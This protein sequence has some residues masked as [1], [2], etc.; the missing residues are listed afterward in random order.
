MKRTILA[1]RRLALALAGCAWAGIVHAGPALPT[2][3]QVQQ[4]Q[5]SAVVNGNKLTVTNSNGAILN[6]SSFSIGAANAV[7]FEQPGSTSKVLNRVTG[8]DPSQILGSLSSNGQVWLLNP[9]GVLFG[10]GARVDVAGLVTSTLNLND[11]DWTAG[12]YA[13]TGGEAATGQVLNQ[14]EIRSAAGGQ[15]LLLAGAGG[16]RNEGLIDTAGGQIVL[17]AGASIE[18]L[19]T[20]APRL[21]VHVTAPAGEAL[22][23]GSIA[24]GRIDVQAASVNQLGVVR[25]DALGVGPGGEIVLQAAPGQLTLGADSRTTADAAAGAGGRIELLG[26]RVALL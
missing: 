20:A 12:R 16:V 24:G 14:G 23:L 6:W 3:L 17:A 25:A 11:L 13:F 19:D 26:R 1:P 8:N 5:A 10:S 15:V 18:L 2:G 4:G 21:T 22:N 9:N 7:R